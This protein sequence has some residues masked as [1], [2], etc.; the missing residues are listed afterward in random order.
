MDKHIQTYC[1][2]DRICGEVGTN[3]H[4]LYPNRK[5]IWEDQWPRSMGNIY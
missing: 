2:V 4:F 5:L 3:L 1:Q